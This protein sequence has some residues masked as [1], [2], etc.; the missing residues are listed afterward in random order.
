MSS[1]PSILQN[2][3]Y[4]GRKRS[5]LVLF[6][7]F[8][9]LVVEISTLSVCKAENLFPLRPSLKAH[10]TRLTQGANFSRELYTLSRVGDCQRQVAKKDQDELSLQRTLRQQVD[11]LSTDDGVGLRDNPDMGV[12]RSEQVKFT[13][14][15]RLAL[16]Q[17]TSHIR[18]RLAQREMDHALAHHL[19]HSL[20]DSPYPQRSKERFQLIEAISL[21]KELAFGP[22]KGMLSPKSA[23]DTLL[24]LSTNA[25]GEQVRASALA[26]ISQQAISTDERYQAALE[27]WLNYPQTP[28]SGRLPLPKEMDRDWLRRGE[29]A[30]KARD[31]KRT[32]EALRYLSPLESKIDF[33]EVSRSSHQSKL[34]FA[35]ENEHAVARQRSG[36]LI[37]ISLMRLREYPEETERQ[38]EVAVNGPNRETSANALFYQVHLF[39]R[40]GRWDESL[41]KLSAYLRTSPRG[42]QKSEALY[43]VGRIKHQAGRYQ[44]AIEELRAFINHRPKDPVMYEWFLGWSYFR[45]G[46]CNGAIKVWGPLKTNRNLV[47]GPKA[48]YWTA[49]CFA[50]NGDKRRAK[51]ELRSLLKV[52]PLGYYALLAQTLLARLEDREF[53]WDNPLKSQRLRHWKLAAPPVP[54]RS[55][56]R[57]KKSRKTAQLGFEIEQAFGLVTLGE[58]GLARVKA[59]TICRDQTV[60]KQLNRVLGTKKTWQICD[61]L[62][63]YTGDHGARWKRQASK[64]VAWKTGFHKRR[65]WERVEAYPIAYYDLS[66]SAAELEGLTPWWL[67]AHMLQES[68]YRPEVVSHA[69]AIGLLQILGRTGKRIQQAIKWPKGEFFSDVLYDPAISVR[70][71][72]WYLHHLKEDLGHPLLAIGAYNGGPMRFADHQDEFKGQDFDIMVE[73]L[74]AHESRNYLRKVA[75]HFIR[76]L[77]LYATDAEWDHWT[78]ALAPPELTPRP[79]R[80]VGF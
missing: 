41:S 40:L 49:R 7:L 2:Q 70:Y 28:F 68:R 78:K 36:L 19:S 37:A 46:D 80:T 61:S 45:N 6:C 13:D 33:V 67:M 5:I 59:K 27:L 11:C 26:T 52:S 57:L 71:A 50:K 23:M 65:P 63:Y 21:L 17:S 25:L 12:S 38:L 1:S 20:K 16:S 69:Q 4:L 76:Y 53:T 47:I 55:V 56:S 60:K 58:E 39:S 42:R 15:F 62:E 77:S 66:M 54:E 72:A 3:R 64:R 73:E 35:S 34:N 24:S 48:H 44:E 22:V 29:A 14:G 10:E 8:N 74:G 75:D 18:W 79:K 31:Y 30:F 43:Q 51:T 9:Y 32:I